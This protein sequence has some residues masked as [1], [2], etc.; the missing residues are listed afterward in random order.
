M[1]FCVYD[2]IFRFE[3]SVQYSLVVQMFY[4]EQCLNKVEFCIVFLHFF[5]FPQQVEEFTSGAV[6]HAKHDVII[7]FEGEI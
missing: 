7:S 4:G 1:S 5:D 6:L 2:N 3:V